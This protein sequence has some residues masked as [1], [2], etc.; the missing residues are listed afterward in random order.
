VP[1][2]ALAALIKFRGRVRPAPA[3]DSDLNFA[4]LYLRASFVFSAMILLL[5]SVWGARMHACASKTKRLP[6]VHAKFSEQMMREGGRC[7]SRFE[8]NVFAAQKRLTVCPARWSAVCGKSGKQFRR[9]WAGLV[10]SLFFISICARHTMGQFYCRF[11]NAPE[12]MCALD[13]GLAGSIYH[14]RP[15]AHIVRFQK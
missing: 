5:N 2:A 14:P 10:I 8:I 6:H 15:D 9:A 3:F 7:F 13:V 1:K 11:L 12:H 4:H